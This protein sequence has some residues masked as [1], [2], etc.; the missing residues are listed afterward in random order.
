MRSYHRPIMRFRPHSTLTFPPELRLWVLPRHQLQPPL[1]LRLWP[2][3]RRQLAAL[4]LLLV[5]ACDLLPTG[6]PRPHEARLLAGNHQTAAAG[7][8]LILPLTVE[9]L[10]KGEQPVRGVQVSWT[11]SAGGGAL[12]SSA[13]ETDADGRAQARWILGPEPGENRAVARVSGLPDVEFWAMAQETPGFVTA[14]YLVPADRSVRQEYLE[15]IENAMVHLRAWYQ[16]AMGNQTTFR[17]SEPAVEVV[18][19]SEPVEWFQSWRYGWPGEQW[20]II[21]NA[22]GEARRHL[23]WQPAERVLLVFVDAPRLCGQQSAAAFATTAVVD[24]TH[25]RLMATGELINPCHGE[26]PFEGDPC[27]AVGVAGHELGHLF[28]LGHSCHRYGG[29]HCRRSIMDSGYGIYPN[30]ILL[31][32]ERLEL[33]AGIFFSPEEPLTMPSYCGAR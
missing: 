17:L 30:S 22:E 33:A 28:R 3:A 16:D 18:E 7:A 12:Q 1:P 6:V 15:S 2:A 29:P 32:E 24:G 26:E 31:E 8:E 23:G 25:L 11:V 27:Q 19:S 5:A 14:V 9:V 4:L 13:V 21:F 20:A 10:D